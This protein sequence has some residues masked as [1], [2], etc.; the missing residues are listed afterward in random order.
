[1][2]RKAITGLLAVWT[3]AVRTHS[4]SFYHF[5][6]IKIFWYLSNLLFWI[7]CFREEG[8][9]VYF[10]GLTVCRAQSIMSRTSFIIQ[11]I[12]SFTTLQMTHDFTVMCHLWNKLAMDQHYCCS[13]HHRISYKT[14]LLHH[15]VLFGVFMQLFVL[16]REKEVC[17]CMYRW[18]II[19]LGLFS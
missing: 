16:W 4:P 12:F 2:L 7:Y 17:S 18:Y 9:F 15:S 14:V 3:V 1:M 8:G 19:F 13:P 10:V 6:F 5:N 11:G